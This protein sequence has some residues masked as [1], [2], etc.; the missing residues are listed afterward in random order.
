MSTIPEAK[1]ARE[2]ELR[3]PSCFGQSEATGSDVSIAF[4]AT[5]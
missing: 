1:L 5:P 2:A 3:C 4:V